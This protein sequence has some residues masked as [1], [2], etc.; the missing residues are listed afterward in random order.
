[1]PRPIGFKKKEPEIKPYTSALLHPV[2]ASH[3]SSSQ[4]VCVFSVDMEARFVV[5]L[6]L[7]CA[8][9]HFTEAQILPSSALNSNITRTGCGS[10]KL[11]VSNPFKCTP[12]TT[13]SCFFSSTQ[14][15]NAV[16]TV[17]LTGLVTGYV[18]LGLNPSNNETQQLMGPVV[19]VCGN[20]NSNFFFET[21]NQSGPVLTPNV[22]TTNV[23]SVQGSITGNLIQCTFNISFNSTLLTAAGQL[24]YNV[25]IFNG[26][27]NG[28]ALG[29]ATTVFQSFKFLNLANAMSNIPAAATFNINRT[30]CGVSKLCIATGPNCDPSVSSSCFFTSIQATSQNFL[31]ELSGTTSGFVALG[32]TQQGS[33]VVFVCANNNSFNNIEYFFLPAT[34]VGKRLLPVNVDTVYSNQG[35]VSENKSLIQC[36]FNTSSSFSNVSIKADSVFTV[37]LMNGSTS[38]STLGDPDT[39][40][41]L[42]VDISNVTALN[43][44]NRHVISLWTSVLVL[45]ISA[46]TLRFI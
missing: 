9:G 21:A 32:L 23:T 30:G 11:C 34:K 37:T 24:P 39:Q 38:G 20:N 26:T 36:I 13:S 12:S 28:T 33:N 43:N 40:L 4:C 5:L 42:R 31:F 6:V 2:S 35:V 8:V 10:S 15:T 25:S 44:S 22:V 1:M 46:L 7:L 17:E 45:L 16:L 3:P 19:F 14:L 29:N 41:E 18:A 27:T